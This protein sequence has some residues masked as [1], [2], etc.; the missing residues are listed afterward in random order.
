MLA[1]ATKMAAEADTEAT[2][3]RA[4]AQSESIKIV[5]EAEEVCLGKL[6]EQLS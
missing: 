3:I 6:K 2:L 5:A 4:K 1:I